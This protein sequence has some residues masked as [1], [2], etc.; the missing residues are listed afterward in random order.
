MKKIYTLGIIIVMFVFYGCSSNKFNDSGLEQSTI[1]VNQDNI[2]ATIKD[3]IIKSSKENITVVLENK[4]EYEHSYGFDF[5]LEIELDNNWYK[6]PFDKNP[7]FIEIAIILKGNGKSE[8]V[9]E[10]SKYFTNLPEGKYRIVKSLYLDGEEIVV[11][12]PFE[13]NNNK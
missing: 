4:T 9:I 3:N 7:Q 8:D 1:I 5:N 10:L 12:A 2:N 6:V 11:S 13:I